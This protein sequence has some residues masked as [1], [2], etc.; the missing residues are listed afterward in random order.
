MYEETARRDST[1]CLSVI[2]PAKS[3]GVVEDISEARV[4]SLYQVVEFLGLGRNVVEEGIFRKTGT[5]RKQQ[6]L[7]DRIERGEDLEL[8]AG[9]FSIHECASVLK[10]F[11]GNLTE[12][13]ATN[14]CYK[15][16]LGVADFQTQDFEK[17]LYCTQLLLELIPDQ[18]FRLLKDLLFLLN[19]VA[20]RE[21][22]NKMTASNLGMMFSTHI[23]CPKSLSAEDLA[24]KHPL[25]SRAT[26]F[27]IENPIELFRLSDNCSLFKEVQKFISRR[28][29]DGRL[30]LAKRSKLGQPGVECLIANTVFSFVDKGAHDEDTVKNQVENTVV[31]QLNISLDILEIKD[32]N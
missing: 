22:E 30:S 11:L 6:E 23:L 27:M 3:S 16:H 25:V 17:R 20:Q 14:A 2:M 4:G 15:A 21:E 12:P 13:L 26:T 7:L 24:S 8:E 1:G 29:S 5:V 9:N 32:S 18:Y 10:T 28:S 19:G 31:S